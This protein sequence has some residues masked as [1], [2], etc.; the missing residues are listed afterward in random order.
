MKTALIIGAAVE[1]LLFMMASTLEAK[2]VKFHI[3][4]PH[5][6]AGYDWDH[7]QFQTAGKMMV[8]KECPYHYDYN[9]RMT[10]G[11]I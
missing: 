3:H 2:P 7:T 4:T 9:C 1:F 8:V 10:R 6:Y 11:T 5:Q